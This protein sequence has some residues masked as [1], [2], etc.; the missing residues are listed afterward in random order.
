M[1]PVLVVSHDAGG[2][3]V[4]SA[5]VKA[6]AGSG[7]RFILEGPAVA[8]FRRKL[9]DIDISSA[10]AMHTSISAVEFVLT[11]TGY[12]SDLERTAIAA[13]RGGGVPVA[14]YL[15]HWTNY[16]ERFEL[17]G[18]LVLPNEIWAGDPHAVALAQKTFPRTP[19]KAV[20]NEYFREMKEQIGAL[21]RPEDATPT[22]HVLYVTEPTSA[23]AEKAYGDPRYWGYTE[24]EALDGYLSHLEGAAEHVAV[25]VRRHPAEI[26]GKYSAVIQRHRP[27][28]SITESSGRTLVEDCAW[29][30][31]VVGC[32]SMAM[33]IAVHANKRVFSCI[34]K[35]GPKLS[36]PYAEIVR[37]FNEADVPG[38]YASAAL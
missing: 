35:G 19:V 30:D 6:Q 15:D 4:V 10:S 33:V 20:E 2:A 14:S 7:F 17:C 12:G 36:L 1:K 37:L 34:P 32:D 11:G 18:E 27:L 28:L 22:L 21:A 31:W 8:V 25:V 29:A 5:W 26:A 38:P 16:R 24:I 9:G 23:A 3:E 13:A